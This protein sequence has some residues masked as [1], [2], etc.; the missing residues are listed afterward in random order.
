MQYI[1]EKPLSA[2]TKLCSVA[3]VLN[4]YV[5]NMFLIL[6]LTLFNEGDY[7]TYT[8]IYHKALSLV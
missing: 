2:M 4:S 8:S 7:L 3:H 1:F 5:V 6:V